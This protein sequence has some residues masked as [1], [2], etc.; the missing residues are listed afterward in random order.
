MTNGPY[1]AATQWLLDR[2]HDPKVS[3]YHRTEI[4]KFLMQL[5]GPAFKEREPWPGEARIT[6]VIGGLPEHASV[7]VSREPE[8]IAKDPDHLRLN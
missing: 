3:M 2:M 8:Q 7:S 5:L 6:I 4:A 1:D